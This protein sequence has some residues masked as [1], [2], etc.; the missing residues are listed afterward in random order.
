M[1]RTATYETNEVVSLTGLTS[2]LPSLRGWLVVGNIVEVR[3][4]DNRSMKELVLGLLNKYL[5][6]RIT[7]K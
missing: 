5:I 4:V 3:V 6:N 1:N 2:G 7:S